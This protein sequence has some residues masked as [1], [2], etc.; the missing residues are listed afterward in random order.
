MKRPGQA[1]IM[2]MQSMRTE[3]CAMKIITLCREYGAGGH[4]IGRKVA[5]ELGIEIYDRDIIEQSAAALGIDPGQLEAE[6]EGISRRETFLRAITPISYERKDAMY[7]AEC[8]VIRDLAKKGP[9]VFLG[10]CADAVLQE[11]GIDCFRVF[12]YGDEQHRSKRVGELIGSTNPSEIQKA[13]KKTDQ[14]RRSYYTHYT[15][16]TWGDH[17]NFHLCLDTGVLGYD[18]CVRLICEAVKGMEE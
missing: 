15:G 16:R 4:S 9:C 10:R 6:E 5:A 7:D 11:A 18:N 2:F 13:L 14:A 3:V 12:L 8:A 1:S 17:T